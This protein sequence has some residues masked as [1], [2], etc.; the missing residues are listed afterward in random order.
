MGFPVIPLGDHSSAAVDAF[1][2]IYQRIGFQGEIRLNASR[3]IGVVKNRTKSL[4]RKFIK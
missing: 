1:S 2:K 4:V 3:R